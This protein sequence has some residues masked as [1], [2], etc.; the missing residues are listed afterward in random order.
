[1]KTKFFFLIGLLLWVAFSCNDQEKSETNDPAPAT[2]YQNGK[3]GG[4]SD[5]EI[6][7]AVEEAAAFVVSQ[8]APPVKLKRILSVKKQVVKGLNYDLTFELENGETWNA[9][10]YRDLSGNFSFLKEPS[11]RS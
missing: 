2:Q 11:R 9:V 3:A 10:V 6:D 5:A 7:E 4:W 1:M 8:I